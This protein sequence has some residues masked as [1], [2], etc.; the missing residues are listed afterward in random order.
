MKKLTELSLYKFI[1]ERAIEWHNHEY[2][3]EKNI[4]VLIP[5]WEIEDFSKLI[6]SCIGEDGIECTMR[7]GYFGFWMNE[8][9]ENAGIEPNNVFIGEN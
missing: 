3:G 2:Q 9:C 1:T 4:V 6:K 5:M 7:D 8:I